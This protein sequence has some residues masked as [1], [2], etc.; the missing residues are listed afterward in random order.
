MIAAGPEAA[1][2]VD[3][4]AEADDGDPAT[5]VPQPE[6]NVLFD[7][8]SKFQRVFVVEEN[9]TRVLRFDDVLGSDQST[10]DLKDPSRVVFEY[11]R[12]AG[13]AT[14]L[15]KQPTSALVI[16]I[17]GGAFPRLLLQQH[18]KIIV[19]A[20]DIDPV[21]VEAARR[22]FLLP[23]TPRLQVHIEDGARYVAH[24]RAGY[25]LILLDAFSGT[26]IPPALSSA[27]FFADTRRVLAD[28]GVVVM[29]VALVSEEETQLI[30]GRFAEAFPGCVVVTGKAEENVVL[31]G[32]RTLVDKD[33]VRVAALTSSTFLPY[34]SQRDIESIRDCPDPKPA[35]KSTSKPEPKQ[36]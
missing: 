17:G 33:G 30:I 32:A 9:G 1:P 23:K 27:A 35:P 6:R 8:Q 7:Q 15:V 22:F 36:R 34:D 14:R 29:N 16:G 31:F 24:A 28:R 4:A 13:L 12:L 18:P 26:G 5:D 19:D 3:V 11:V 21:V 10:L 2:V 25:D 20:V